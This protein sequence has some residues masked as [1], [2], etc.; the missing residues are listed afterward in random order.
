MGYLSPVGRHSQDLQCKRWSR[1][2]GRPA[3]SR[4]QGCGRELNSSGYVEA[5]AGGQFHQ[6]GVVTASSVE[7]HLGLGRLP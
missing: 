2:I 6:K 7:D 1:A 4:L 3:S 5:M